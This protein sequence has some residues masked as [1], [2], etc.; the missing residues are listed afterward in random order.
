MRRL[1]F[2][3]CPILLVLM[4]SIPAPLVAQSGSSD[5]LS[6]KE[7][8]KES[9]RLLKQVRNSFVDGELA[10]ALAS[11]DSILAIDEGNPDAYHYWGRI[12]IRQADTLL[13]DSVL[14]AGIEH[15]P[16]SSRLKLY[17]SRIR[18]KQG[19][20]ESALSL[21]EGVLAIKPRESEALYLK[22]M[23]L[24]QQGDSAQATEVLQRATEIALARR[25]K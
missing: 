24:V 9:R 17:L 5:G 3:S 16:K 1:L 25:K 10:A 8:R 7:R 21:A 4:L 15:A 2:C 13:A 12:L 11:V 19:K 6:A 14:D 18:L 20:T 22:G 23:A